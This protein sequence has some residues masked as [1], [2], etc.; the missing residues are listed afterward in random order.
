M[1]TLFAIFFILSSLNQAPFLKSLEIIL[2]GGGVAWS[3]IFYQEVTYPTKESAMKRFVMVKYLS[4]L[5]V[6]LLSLP[7]S[8]V[9]FAQD[10]S[11]FRISQGVDL[12][13]WDPHLEQ[14][15][16]QMTYYSL[17]FDGLIGENSDGSTRPGLATEW[18]QTTEY[19]D[20]TLR[21]G[22]LFHDGTAFNAEAVVANVDKVKNG[23]FPPTANMLRA[24]ESVE[25]VGEYQVRF[26]LAN[27]APA[28]LSDLQ[29]FAGLMMSPAS[30]ETSVEMPVG[31]GPYIFNAEESTLNSRYV[32]D[33]NPTYWDPSVQNVDRIE[34]LII[35]DF[36]TAYNAVVAGE[37]DAA[38]IFNNQVAQALAE[39]YQVL[40]PEG[41]G[42]GFHIF[43]RNGT[44]VPEF[45]DVRVR[46]A[47][48][49]AVDRDAYYQVVEGGVGA[50]LVSTQR[51]RSG[52]YAH[53]ADI[54]DLN[55]NL[56]RAKELM[57]EA[58]VTGF[59]F[60]VPAA[61]RF[62]R[63]SQALAGFFA[64]IGIEMIVE[65]IA[66]GTIFTEVQT[67][68]WAAAFV[69]VNERHTSGYYNS[70]ISPNGFLNPFKVPVANA[71]ELAAQARTLD[72]AEAE[73]LW[74]EIN[75]LA[76]EEGAIIHL[77]TVVQSIMV[78]PETVATLEAM[79]FAPFVADYRSLTMK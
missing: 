16:S 3:S 27:P 21:E 40:Q 4:L 70:R 32:F 66:L 57:A 20:L 52:Q 12:A 61:G 67:G 33:K 25:V 55:Y 77:G 17:P 60:K 7:V 30:F 19:L 71:D 15:V 74:A 9:V 63:D 35:P 22:V 43:D 72:V 2:A 44:M 13:T 34:V 36:Q 10:M 68:N 59:S 11:V 65:P 49:L 53:C 45:A 23:P 39:G 64:E 31:T 26:N 58:G 46:Q 50:S 75:C 18:E 73:P 69:P 1:L 42:L 56:E 29:R 54:Q 5:F 76:A 24:V 38:N 28:L 14:N 51:F 37:L 48:A 78:N 41:F 47:M 6:L 79:Y 8:G 62:Q